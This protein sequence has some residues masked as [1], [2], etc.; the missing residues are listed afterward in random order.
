MKITYMLKPDSIEKIKSKVVLIS[1][2]QRRESGLS[3][4]FRRTF[5]PYTSERTY[6]RCLQKAE[7]DFEAFK[8]VIANNC[9]YDTVLI[10]WSSYLG[11]TEDANQGFLYFAQ[12]CHQAAAVV[13]VSKIY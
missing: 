1:F 13:E 11:L 6:K 2:F 4:S 3:S 9:Q 5:S 12:G 7:T 8:Y 10:L